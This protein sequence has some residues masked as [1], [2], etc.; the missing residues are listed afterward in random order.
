VFFGEV[1]HPAG[2]THPLPPSDERDGDVGMGTAAAHRPTRAYTAALALSAYRMNN[3]KAV[4]A[5]AVTDIAV[6]FRSHMRMAWQIMSL[7][8]GWSLP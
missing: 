5:Q 1:V 7:R 6:R 4:I 3:A 2:H 8:T